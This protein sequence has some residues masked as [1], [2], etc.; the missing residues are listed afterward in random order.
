MDPEFF[1]EMVE[2]VGVGVA[3]YGSDGR[4]RYVNRAYADLFG[5]DRDSLVGTAL[6]EINPGFERERFDTYWESFDDGETRTARPTTSS[7][8]RRSPW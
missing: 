1:E 6:W 3:I 8:G 7:R 2:T 4:Y 5:A